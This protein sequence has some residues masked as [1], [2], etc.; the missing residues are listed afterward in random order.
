MKNVRIISLGAAVLAGLA[1]A[2]PTLGIFSGSEE[3]VSSAVLITVALIFVAGFLAVA[4]SVNGMIINPSSLRG[5][6]I[7]AGGLVA[8]FG[9]SYFLADGSDFAQYNN[10]DEKTTKWVSTGLNAF[11]ICFALAIAAVLYSS[12]SRIRK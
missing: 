11:Y 10:V 2:I 6:L 5:A 4:S 3:M 9:L 8:I 1:G 12:L 7:G